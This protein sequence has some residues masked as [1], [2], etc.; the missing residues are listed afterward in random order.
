MRDPHIESE[1][2]GV[3]VRNIVSYEESSGPLLSLDISLG[4]ESSPTSQASHTLEI[5][6]LSRPSDVPE[7]VLPGFSVGAKE[8]DWR[9]AAWTRSW[10]VEYRCRTVYFELVGTE[11][12]DDR[13]V[14]LA[15]LDWW[16]ADCAC[17]E[18]EARFENTYVT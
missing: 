11:D 16:K 8:Q 4:A 15:W 18:A 9:F 13:R 6:T 2:C 12:V 5:R 10:L 17:R 7:R 3:A 14:N 1:L